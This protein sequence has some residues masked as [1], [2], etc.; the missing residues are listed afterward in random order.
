[1]TAK[2]KL[3]AAS[4]GGSFSLQAPSSSANN[5][6]FTLPDVAD[7]TMAT[8]NGITMAQIWR[9]NTSF[10]ASIGFGAIDSNWE[11]ADHVNVGYIGSSMSESSGVFT[12]PSTGIYSIQFICN[13]Y[14]NGID[15]RYLGATIRTTANNG[16]SY[17]TVS[18]NYGSIAN[19]SGATFDNVLTSTL[20]DVTDTST[21][22]CIFSIDNIDSINI[23]GH[24]DKNYTYVV[25]TRLGDT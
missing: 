7:A 4:G 5:R 20:F 10:A 15:R 13:F 8:V 14:G 19:I 11:V 1:M 16:S 25:F 12:F 23:H 24:S 22:K 18:T 2:I 21:H 9:I 3:N 6:V 17:D